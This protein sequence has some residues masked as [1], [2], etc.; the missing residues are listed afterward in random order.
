MSDDDSD[1]L[2]FQRIGEKTI[3]LDL[4]PQDD[5]P[6]VVQKG[7]LDLF[8]AWLAQTPQERRVMPR[9]QTR[10]FQVWLGWK[11]KGDAF[12]ANTARM[13]DISRGGAQLLVVDPP[14]ERSRVWIC[15][16]KPDPSDC[17]EATVLEVRIVSQKVWTVRL[18]FREPCPHPFFEAAVCILSPSDARQASSSSLET[19][20]DEG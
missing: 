6:E 15:L 12:F 7:L 9:H 2:Q 4:P 5:E 3:R 19:G 20:G 14:R 11:K 16:G 10:P 18:A 17:L 1:R 13:V 8:R